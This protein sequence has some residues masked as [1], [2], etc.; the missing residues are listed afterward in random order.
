M[1]LLYI[2]LYKITK[3]IFKRLVKSFSKV[4]LVIIKRKVSPT[5]SLNLTALY[6]TSFALLLDNPAHWGYPVS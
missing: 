2:Y 6:P 1:C 5:D 4:N 3:S